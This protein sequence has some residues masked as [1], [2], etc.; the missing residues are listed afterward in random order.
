MLYKSI[1]CIIFTQNGTG[2][3][4]CLSERE[5]S[6]VDKPRRPSAAEWRQNYWV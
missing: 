5:F 4:T 6:H 3:L 2:S 1:T